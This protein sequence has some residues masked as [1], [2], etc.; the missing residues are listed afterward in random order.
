MRV[1]DSS[2]GGEAAQSHTMRWT[3]VLA[4]RR[5]TKVRRVEGHLPPLSKSIGIPCTPLFAGADIHCMMPL[6]EMLKF[7]ILS[8]QSDNRNPRPPDALAFCL[9]YSA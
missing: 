3:L 1:S 9:R 2:V 6:V 7:E 8:Y 5:G 4:L